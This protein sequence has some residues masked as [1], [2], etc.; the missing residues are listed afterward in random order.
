MTSSHKVCFVPCKCS[1]PRER[2]HVLWLLPHVSRFVW[3]LLW[4]HGEAKC[5]LATAS[6]YACVSFSVFLTFQ[7]VEVTQL[8][9]AII[10]PR[11]TLWLT[12]LEVSS[13]ARAIALSTAHVL[14]GAPRQTKLVLL[15]ETSHNS[16]SL[17]FVHFFCHLCDILFT[18][19][20]LV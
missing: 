1:E 7:W 10:K 11:G 19:T 18:L 20:S 9:S 2:A 17:L 13:A 3:T 15:L 6:L 16:V 14:T 8:Y 5:Y 12:P 4:A